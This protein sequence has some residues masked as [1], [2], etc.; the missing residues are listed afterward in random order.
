MNGPK[1]AQAVHDFETKT[2]WKSIKNSGKELVAM[3]QKNY[4]R[5]L[6]GQEPVAVPLNKLFL[7]NPVKTT[8]LIIPASIS[9]H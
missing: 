6:E 8:F 9:T 3:C 7:G 1:L 2:G 5:E 4:E